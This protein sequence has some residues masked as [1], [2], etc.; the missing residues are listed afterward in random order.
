M[1]GRTQSPW[2]SERLAS[3]TTAAA[4]RAAGMADAPALA[5]LSA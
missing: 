2:P 5:R 3:E 1:S 4:I